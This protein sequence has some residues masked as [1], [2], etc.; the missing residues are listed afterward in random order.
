MIIKL[1]LIFL[2]PLLLYGKTINNFES[3]FKAISQVES[4]NNTNS[5]NKREG[6]IGIVQ[7]RYLYFLDSQAFGK[8]KYKHSDCYSEEISKIITFNYFLRYQNKHN[9]E[10]EKMAKIHNGGC[11]FAKKTGQAAKNLEIY[12]GKV[13]LELKQAKAGP[14]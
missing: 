1:F 9:W 2:A 5:F 3:F 10:F 6:A 7:I 11:N 13:S 4:G 12:W 8:T 14:N